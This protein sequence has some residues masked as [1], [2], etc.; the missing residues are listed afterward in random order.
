VIFSK[1]ITVNNIRFLIYEYQRNEEFY[2]RFQSELDRNRN[3]ISGL[4]RFEKADEHKAQT[5]LNDLLQ[6]IHFKE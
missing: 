5:A 4:I 3:N 1:I 2:L 6:T